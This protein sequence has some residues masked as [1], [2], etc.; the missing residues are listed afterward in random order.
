MAGF[1]VTPEEFDDQALDKLL[2]ETTKQGG[3]VDQSV[4]S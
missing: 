1:E 3:P 4:R 2:E